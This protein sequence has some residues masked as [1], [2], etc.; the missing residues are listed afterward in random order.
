MKARKFY[1][2]K[3]IMI[4]LSIGFAL[5]LLGILGAI[6]SSFYLT[7]SNASVEEYLIPVQAKTK[8]KVIELNLQEN[9]IVKKGEIIAELEASATEENAKKLYRIKE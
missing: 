1:Q 5:I 9:M 3:R 2:K 6:I 4:P 8:G 7:T